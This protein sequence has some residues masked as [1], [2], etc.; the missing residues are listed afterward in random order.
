VLPHA[1]PRSSSAHAWRFTN[2]M[3]W[4][5]EAHEALLW[6]DKPTFLGG[7]T[8]YT[9]VH[10][11]GTVT[12]TAK[13]STQ[14]K[15]FAAINACLEGGGML[16][17]DAASIRGLAHF[18]RCGSRSGQAATQ[19]LT[20]RQRDKRSWALTPQLRLAADTD[21]VEAMRAVCAPDATTTTNARAGCGPR[22]ART[23]YGDNS[24]ANAV[25]VDGYSAVGDMARIVSG[26]HVRFY[27]LRCRPWTVYVASDANPAD[28]STRPEM[29]TEQDGSLGRPRSRAM[30][31][32]E[33]PFPDTPYCVTTVSGAGRGIGEM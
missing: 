11:T 14:A 8:D 22:T 32:T 25:L 10:A 4:G 1:V 29:W 27:R 20:D 33:I 24:P 18:V 7:V 5:F 3:G 21:P 28:E 2:L 19:P 31:A 26:A 9:S 6:S 30:G 13:A 12:L 15:L 17:A 23:M 16:S